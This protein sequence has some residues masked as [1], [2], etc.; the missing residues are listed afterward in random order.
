[1]SATTVETSRG[2]IIAA[3]SDALAQ[4]LD[5]ELPELT[6]ETRLFEQLG[7]DSTGVLELLMLLE[8]TLEIEV[9]ADGIEMSNFHSVGS[10]ADFVTA[11]MAE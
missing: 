10:L 6:E 4:V 9:D 11:E 1:M 8:D 3:I 7:L 5:T 2:R